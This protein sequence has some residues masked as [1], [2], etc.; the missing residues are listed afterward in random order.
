MNTSHG[1]WCCMHHMSGGACTIRVVQCTSVLGQA[2]HLLVLCPSLG[3]VLLSQEE[4]VRCTP[5]LALVLHAS[6]TGAA[7]L[8]AGAEAMYSSNGAGLAQRTESSE[9]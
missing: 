3:P 5:R 7:Q 9:R 8:A 1:R 2:L 4:L 6:K